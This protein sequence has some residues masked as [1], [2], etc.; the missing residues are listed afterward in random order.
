MRNS[1]E[2]STMILLFFPAIN[3]YHLLFYDFYNLLH[4]SYS[5]LPD[6]HRDLTM[7]LVAHWANVAC[8]SFFYEISSSGTSINMRRKM[9]GGMG[10]GTKLLPDK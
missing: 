9:D 7:L 8:L 10:G 2:S 3:K 4:D 5:F 1:S 6:F